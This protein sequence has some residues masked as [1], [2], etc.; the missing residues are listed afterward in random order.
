MVIF[1]I[2]ISVNN[3]NQQ[4]IFVIIDIS[5]A[6]DASANGNVYDELK[7]EFHSGIVDVRDL[8]NSSEDAI[9]EPM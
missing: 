4:I 3:F 9:N 1:R 6:A 2:H 7:D 8:G 5:N